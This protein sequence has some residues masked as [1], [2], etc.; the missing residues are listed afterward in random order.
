[1]IDGVAN[2]FL[3]KDWLKAPAAAVP[4]PVRIAVKTRGALMALSMSQS[5]PTPVEPI[6]RLKPAARKSKI[7][8]ANIFMFMPQ[9]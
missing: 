5:A 1:M 7:V 6:A 9:N 2:E 8:R 3:N 4:A